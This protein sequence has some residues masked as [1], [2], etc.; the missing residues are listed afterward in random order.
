MTFKAALQISPA[1]G[2]IPLSGTLDL[3]KTGASDIRFGR[4]QLALPATQA[5][6]HGTLG[7][8]IEAAI[9]T[10]NLADVTSVLDFLKINH[11]VIGSV[12]LLPGG[13]AHFAGSFAGSLSNPS[14]KGALSLTRLRVAGEQWDQLHA[15]GTVTPGSLDCSSLTA[16]SAILHASGSGHIELHDWQVATNA[17]I[18]L[19]ATYNGLDVP[20]FLSRYT[21]IRSPL[22][23]GTASGTLD[24]AGS[25]QQPSG[26][27][28]LT[29]KSLR[30]YGEAADQ[31]EAVAV[32]SANDLR[33]QHASIEGIAG[34]RLS[35]SGLYRH[36]RGDWQNGQ[37]S[38]QTN[39]GDLSVK[40]FRFVRAVAPELT[41]NA[42]IDAQFAAHIVNGF[43]QLS[44]IDGH[45]VVRDLSSNGVELGSVNANVTTQSE[46]MNFVLQGDLRDTRFHGSAQVKLVQDAPVTG[47]LQ[48]DRISLATLQSLGRPGKNQD[49]RLQGFLSG[50]IEFQGA[51]AHLPLA[52]FH[53]SHRPPPTHIVAAARF[54]S[55]Q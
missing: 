29:I 46:T 45:A 12:V 47:K 3:S 4:S 37:L 24:I 55:A 2:G 13:S 21:R 42:Y 22:E 18:R 31:L 36:A 11:P 19:H 51:L 44:Q 41:G 48:F 40:D 25:I 9:D 32:F 34:G 17:P 50:G 38:I 10:T 35:F 53:R 33:I 26:N 1:K 27:A 14:V 39:G 5:A 30:A 43:A 54:R 6:F 52:A 23:Q 8:G 20:V 49:F 7:T 28:R 15:Q 16:D